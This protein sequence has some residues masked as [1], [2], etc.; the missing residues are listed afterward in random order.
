M[1]THET[2]TSELHVFQLLCFMIAGLW[3]AHSFLYNTRATQR[4]NAE[5]NAIW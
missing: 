2:M 5:W 3:V 1:C 4:S